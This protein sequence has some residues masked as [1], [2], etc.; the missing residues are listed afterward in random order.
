MALGEEEK[1]LGS[2]EIWYCFQCFFCTNKCPWKI[3]IPYIISRLRKMALERGYG[4]DLIEILSGVG[5]NLLESGLSISPR[6]YARLDPKKAERELAEARLD[7]GLPEKYEVSD[8]ALGELKVILEETG[9]KQGL[10]KLEE[11]VK[12]LKESSENY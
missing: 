9:F 5:K 1:V 4:W 6:D 3:G 8:E 7:M 12:E 10:E 11:R 2:K